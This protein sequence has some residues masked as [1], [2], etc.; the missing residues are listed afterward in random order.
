MG[1]IFEMWFLSSFTLLRPP[2]QRNLGAKQGVLFRLIS[3]V[4]RMLPLM[5]INRWPV[6]DPGSSQL[7][8]RLSSPRPPGASFWVC[9]HSRIPNTTPILDVHLY[10]RP[11]DAANTARTVHR[12][13][14]SWH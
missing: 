11:L 7:R 6:G 3:S 8:F 4:R 5:F 12:P 10:Q 9:S 2:E 14:F 1:R 13:S